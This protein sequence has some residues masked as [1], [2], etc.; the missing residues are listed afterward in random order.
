MTQFYSDLWFKKGDVCTYSDTRGPFLGFLTS[1]GVDI[2]VNI[3]LPKKIPSGIKITLNS[4][5][6]NIR[7]PAGGYMG[8]DGKTTYWTEG[9]LDFLAA[10]SNAIMNEYLAGCTFCT[11][12]LI[13]KNAFT[14]N[15]IP[16][17]IEVNEIQ[18]AFS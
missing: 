11:M 4:F 13:L 15:N 9:G 16:I 17:A 1:S 3:P 12:K 18:L 2:F 7:I 10:S 6:A 5:K 14:T 8:T